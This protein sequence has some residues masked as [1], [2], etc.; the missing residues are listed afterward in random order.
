MKPPDLVVFDL[1]GTLVDSVGDLA[2]AV[3]KTLRALAPSVATLPLERVRAFIGSGARTLIARSL[4]ASGI[5]APA[6]DVLPLFL[7]HY[8]DCLLE[9]TVLYPG[10]VE[11]LD[12]LAPRPLAVL[13]NKPGDLSRTLLGGLGVLSRFVRVVGGGDTAAKKP[14]PAGLLAL[15]HELGSTPGAAVIVG[16]SAVD[17]ETGRAAGTGTVGVRY[18]FDPAG[19]TGARPD[20]ILND[21]RELPGA[22]SLS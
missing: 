1:D 18:G 3:N 9:T 15:V 17:V 5:D 16:D 10:A 11:V 8:R 6:Q 13:T 22:L 4:A 14:D 2:T 19:V 12:R 7:E 21:L 20:L